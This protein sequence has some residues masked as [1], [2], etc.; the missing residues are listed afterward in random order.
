MDGREVE[1]VILFADIAGCSSASDALSL[2]KF[3][4]LRRER[5]AATRPSQFQ[6][7][8]SSEARIEIPDLEIDGKVER[9]SQ[10]SC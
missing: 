6:G 5:A 4:M 7:D 2:F 10:R 3:S 8:R 1:A 9:I